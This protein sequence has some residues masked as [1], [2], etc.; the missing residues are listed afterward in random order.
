[1]Q[2]I[3]KDKLKR[4]KNKNILVQKKHLFELTNCKNTLGIITN[5]LDLSS[6]CSYARPAYD[7]RKVTNLLETNNIFYFINNFNYGYCHEISFFMKYLLKLHK[8]KARIVRLYSKKIRFHWVLEIKFKNRW[9]F[10][11]PTFGIL[12]RSKINKKFIGIKELKKLKIK[13]VLWNKRFSL[14]KFSNL[15]KN[16]LFYFKKKKTF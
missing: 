11:D 3:I 2:S 8:I 13:D 16:S 15:E 9:I 1:M 14:K 5:C 6:I 10:A 4:I 12:L 7:Y